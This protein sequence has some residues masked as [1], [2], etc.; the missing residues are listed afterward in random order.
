MIAQL[1]VAQALSLDQAAA[2]RFAQLALNCVRREYPNKLDHTMNGPDEVKAP[3]ALH[4]SFYGCYDWHSSVHGH[5]MLARLLRRFPKMPGAAEI[6]GVLDDHLATPAIAA[7]VA[8][9]GQP[10]RKSFERTYGWAWLLELQAELLDW[11]EAKVWAMQLQPL[12]DTVVRAFE[13]FLPR[14]DYPIRTGV[15]PNT[16]YALQMVLHYARAAHDDKLALLAKERARTYYGKDT[17]APMKW[18]PSGEDFLSPSLEEAALMAQVLPP[19]GFVKWAGEFLPD[20]RKLAPARVSDR[21]DPKIVH[22][23]GLN[24]SRARCLYAL[25]AALPKKRAL[26]RKL[27]D[28]HA[29]ATLPHIESG[30]YEGEHWL[31]TFAVRMLDAR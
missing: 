18:E 20:L 23:D 29:Q 7:E 5:W 28:A 21:T 2:S 25:A 3:K 26:L 6:R 10:N 14:Q 11:P 15:H 4:P 27:A 17:G 13:D 16:A 22:L 1:L 30:G 8:Y 24:L 12:A 9:F 19:K 31:A